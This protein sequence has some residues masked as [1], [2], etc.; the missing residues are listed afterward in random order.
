M[1]IFG[2]IILKN[3]SEKMYNILYKKFSEGGKIHKYCGEFKLYV[4]IYMR[5]HHLSNKEA[6]RLFLPNQKS[7]SAKTIRT[8]KQIYKEKGP[9]GFFNMAKNKELKLNKPHYKI[10]TENKS[11][12]ELIEIIN[13]LNFELNCAYNYLDALKKKNNLKN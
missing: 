4:I 10:N 6:K 2:G 9:L 1:G 11:N 12:E 3:N 8:W 5:E 13:N 7:A